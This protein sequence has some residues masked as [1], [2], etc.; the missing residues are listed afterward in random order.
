MEYAIGKVIS[1]TQNDSQKH[2]RIKVLAWSKNGFWISKE[3]DDHFPPSGMVF[4]PNFK[5]DW[6][7]FTEGDVI[8]FTYDDNPYQVRPGH[9]Q[10][11]LPTKKSGGRCIK[12]APILSI[13][14]ETIY[15][16]EVL[17][18]LSGNCYF[19]YKDKSK[20]YICGPIKAEDSS[21]V[22]G[23]EV[24]A[25]AFREDY[26][27]VKDLE[28]NKCYMAIDENEFSQ[29]DKAFSVDCMSE[30]QLK[31]WFI[32]LVLPNYYSADEL[33]TL[34]ACFKRIKTDT[35]K[36]EADD[37]LTNNRLERFRNH[38]KD[39][40]FSNIEIQ[41][42]GQIPA[43]KEI[44]EKQNA[45]FKD[46]YL[47]EQ[48]RDI[49]SNLQQFREKSEKEMKSIEHEV[50][51]QKDALEQVNSKYS[52]ELEKIKSIFSEENKKVEKARK[53][54]ERLKEMKDDIVELI[55]I[56]S[57]ITTNSFEFPLDVVKRKEM[58]LP[59]KTDNDIASFSTKVMLN[60]RTDI[61]LNRFLHAI[62]DDSWFC[63]KTKSIQSCVF[64]CHYIGNT[65]YEL[66]Q[67]SPSWLSFKEFWNEALHRIWNSA[68]DNPDIW[69]FLIIENFNIAL[70]ECWGAPL[71]NLIDGKTQ[72]LPL[73][74]KT[75]YPTNLKIIVTE[76]PTESEDNSHIGLP[77]KV[78]KS[79]M[80]ID[81]LPEWKESYSWEDFCDSKRNGLPIN[82]QFFFA[83]KKNGR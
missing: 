64:A 43:F 41:K 83:V 17:S 62:R 3:I 70:P 81:Y 23:K 15:K 29:R 47:Q 48:M 38:L 50:K 8:R 73:A 16:R 4:A 20:K 42:L 31:D 51:K 60:S 55:R 59:I 68:H 54:Y 21:P 45:K 80:S 65:I 22:T 28:T 82:E 33:D 53:E 72:Y 32:K 14:M 5:D 77:T 49:Q 66:C 56:E 13:E 19:F 52:S 24:F 71:W 40:S 39:I 67:P 74:E 27:T 25:K 76:A 12:C 18:G 78:C 57:S 11:I 36:I 30:S 61:N 46:D 6:P 10:I 79:W 63:M 34:K 2:A 37:F 44:I 75:G 9:D 1:I 7:M 35:N 69:H 26:D 58:A